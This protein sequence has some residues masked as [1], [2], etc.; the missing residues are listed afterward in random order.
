MQGFTFEYLKQLTVGK[1]EAGI[2]GLFCEANKTVYIGASIEL[3]KRLSRHR[4][5]LKK[6]KHCNIVLQNTFN[7]YGIDT[8]QFLILELFDNITSQNIVEREYFWIQKYKDRLSNYKCLNIDIPVNNW[9]K[10][11]EFINSKRKKIY[12]SKGIK[13]SRA[14]TQTEEYRN[15]QSEILKGRKCTWQKQLKEARHKRPLTVYSMLYSIQD[16]AGNIHKIYTWETLKNFLKSYNIDNNIP[17]HK[18]ISIEK[19]VREKETKEFKILEINRINENTKQMT[20]KYKQ[21]DLK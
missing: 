9:D 18:R 7:K 13:P 6:N 15:R 10:D 11:Q 4:S 12:Q 19:L 16:P 5:H 1:K 3:R 20:I 14:Y 2:Y 21:G 8:F 17:F